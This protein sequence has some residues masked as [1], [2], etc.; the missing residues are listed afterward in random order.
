MKNRSFR[1]L[2]LFLTSGLKVKFQ[3]YY[4]ERTQG[5]SANHLSMTSAVFAKFT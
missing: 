1:K 5:N 2:I 3:K 4:L